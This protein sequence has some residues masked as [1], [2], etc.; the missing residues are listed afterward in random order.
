MAKVSKVVSVSLLTEGIQTSQS[1]FGSDAEGAFPECP[2]LTVFFD[3]NNQMIGFGNQEFRLMDRLSEEGVRKFENFA[4]FLSAQ[5][6]LDW[7]FNPDDVPV[8]DEFRPENQDSI[9]VCFTWSGDARDIENSLMEEE[10]DDWEDELETFKSMLDDSN[11][12]AIGWKYV[13]ECDWSVNSDAELSERYF[14]ANWDVAGEVC[15]VI[16]RY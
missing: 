1:Q 15:F 7:L 3:A 11:T 10:P 6:S 8:S 12:L 5:E 9:G 4:P 14:E 16:Q 2:N 13:R